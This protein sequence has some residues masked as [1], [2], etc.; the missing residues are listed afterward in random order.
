MG[1]IGNGVVAGALTLAALIGIGRGCSCVP[2]GHVGVQTRFGDVKHEKTI[3]QGI[4]AKNVLNRV[5]MMDVRT[6]EILETMEVPTK[7]GLLPTLEVSVLYSR[8][9]DGASHLYET[10]GNAERQQSQFVHPTIRSVIRGVV[11]GYEAKG[12][13]TASRESVSNEIFSGLEAQFEERGYRLEKVLLRGVVLPDQLRT[14]IEEKLQAEQESQKMEFVLDKERQE[15]DRKK[16]EAEGIAGA[17]RIINDTLTDKYLVW[18]NQEVMDHFAASPNNTIIIAPY[19]QQLVPLLNI[20]APN[21]Q[22]STKKGN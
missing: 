13:Y 19:D 17:Q 12:L 4:H 15:S 1:S 16:I 8:S 9:P 7:E 14:S 10:L 21:V 2:T 3:D 5:H 6:T 11:S 22:D 18:R 20:P